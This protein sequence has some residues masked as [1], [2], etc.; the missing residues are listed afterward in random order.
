LPIFRF[1]NILSSLF[2][3]YSVELSSRILVLFIFL[4]LRYFFEANIFKLIIFQNL[5][6]V[7]Q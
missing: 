3:T 6:Y 7:L 1:N 5:N 4:E 2:C